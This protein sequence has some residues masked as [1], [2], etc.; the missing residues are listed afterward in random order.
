MRM[1]DRIARA[2][3]G[4][5]N[6][7]VIEGRGRGAEARTAI[8]MRSRTDVRGRNRAAWRCGGSASAASADAWPA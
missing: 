6:A 2:R 3:A 4:H 1:P 8:D 7:A 5:S